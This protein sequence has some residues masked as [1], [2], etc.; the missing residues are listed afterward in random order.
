[1][2]RGLGIKENAVNVAAVLHMV[3]QERMFHKCE[4]NEALQIVRT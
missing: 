1:M 2:E 4:V 3:L